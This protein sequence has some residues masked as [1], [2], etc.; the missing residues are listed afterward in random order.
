MA[1]VMF[2]WW[3]GP[4]RVAAD[5]GQRVGV[6]CGGSRG[7]LR[8]DKG[9]ER[10]LS[11]L[12]RRLFVSLLLGVG[13]LLLPEFSA[14]SPATTHENAATAATAVVTNN[15]SS[16]SSVHVCRPCSEHHKLCDRNI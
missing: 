7:A 6:G 10:A 15:S 11:F 2:L 1:V 13:K 9:P 4:T 12:S 14:S 5:D 16:S 8:S 3:V